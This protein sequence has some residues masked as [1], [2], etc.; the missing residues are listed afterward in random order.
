MP[1]CMYATLEDW[2]AKYGKEKG[3]YE[4]NLF[5]RRTIVICNQKKL[6]FLDK[7]RRSF[8]L[9]RS[10]GFRNAIKSLGADG[11]ISAEGHV[12]KKDRRMLGPFLNRQRIED[13]V[14][15][16]KLVGSRLCEKWETLMAEDGL[17]VINN[18]LLSAAMDIISLIACGQDLNSVMKGNTQELGEDVKAIVNKAALRC[19][20]APFAYWNIPF[21]GQYL[22]GGGWKAN[23]TRR[24]LKEIVDDNKKSLSASGDSKSCTT[25]ILGTPVRA[26]SKLNFL[27]KLLL[28]GKDQNLLWTW[29]D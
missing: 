18:D 7:Y 13:Y 15:N 4:C 3:V 27:S 21:I 2:A 24:R 11:I 1:G 6:E 26:P 5:G 9:Q 22:D 14:P 17:V 25:S 16:I 29:I 10:E 28:Q 23:R 8:K 20:A 19:V 12:W